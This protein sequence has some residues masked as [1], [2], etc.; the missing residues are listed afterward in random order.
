MLERKD[1]D[2][3]SISTPDHWHSQPLIEAVF[4]G[5]D[6]YVQKPISLTIEEG[7]LVSDAVRQTERIF[8][9]GSQQRSMPQF[10][11]ACEL[12]RNGRLGK[13]YTIEIGLPGDPAGGKP[14]EMP[15]PKNLNYDRWLGSTP[16]VYY[17]EDR[18][19]S[20]SDTQLLTS[21]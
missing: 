11:K 4:S 2:A 12:V 1:I 20:N 19:H 16:S 18:V 9:V 15:V 14:Q 13:V 3:I 7:R 10:H 21:Y 6:V 17:T 5:K 8:L